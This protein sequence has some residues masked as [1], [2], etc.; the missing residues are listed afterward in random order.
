MA[1]QKATREQTVAAISKRYRGG[2][3][4]VNVEIVFDP[5]INRRT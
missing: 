3:Y 5:R 2:D 4:G 1:E